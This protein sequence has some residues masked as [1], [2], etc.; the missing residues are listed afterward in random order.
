MPIKY[1]FT[2]EQLINKSNLSVMTKVAEIFHDLCGG[3]GCDRSVILEDLG[4]WLE[5]RDWTDVTG[6]YMSVRIAPL[7]LNRPDVRENAMKILHAFTN[8]FP[9][10]TVRSEDSEEGFAKGGRMTVWVTTDVHGIAD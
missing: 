1:P 8:L 10:K 9:G 2:P 5:Q 4:S 6:F 3:G 7:D